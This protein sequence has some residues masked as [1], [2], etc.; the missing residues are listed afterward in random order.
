MELTSTMATI[1]IADDSAFVRRLLQLTLADQHTVL[2]AKDGG[3]ALELLRQHQPDVAIL[4][5]VM[6]VLNGFQLCR[7]LRADPDLRNLQIIILSANASEHDALQVGA[8]RFITKPFSPRALLGVIE[9]L[10]DSTRITG[11]ET[12][13]A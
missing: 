12:A 11:G 6:P 10:T 13:C 4:D 9:D 5:V 1:L 2:A 3:E 8:D 7:L